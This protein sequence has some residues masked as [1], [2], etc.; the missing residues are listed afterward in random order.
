MS[1][2]N[3]CDILGWK[4]D[5]LQELRIAGFSYL[6]EGKYDI[7]KIYFEALIVLDPENAY[8]TR[9]LGALYLIMGD[10]VAAIKMLDKALQLDPSHLGTR[11]NRTKALLY[12]G[13]IPEGLEEASKLTTCGEPV[14]SSDAEALI[15]AYSK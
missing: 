10:L 4:E 7:A 5:H 13:N 6:K 15:L 12:L 8:D 2:V 14:I 9:T 11:L 3:W 1:N